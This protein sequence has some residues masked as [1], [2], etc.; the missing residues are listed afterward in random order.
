MENITKNTKSIPSVDTGAYAHIVAEK[1]HRWEFSKRPR[2]K[3]WMSKAR[4]DELKRR[5]V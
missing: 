1:K 2:Q 5:K 3:R 4:F